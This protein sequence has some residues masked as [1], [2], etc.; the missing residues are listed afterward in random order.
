MS[1]QPKVHDTSDFPIVRFDGA[2]I[3]NG[4]SSAWCAEMDELVACGKPFVLIYVAGGPEET[5]D[6]RAQPRRL[7][8]DSQRRRLAAHCSRSSTS[9]RVRIMRA[10]L[11]T[12]LPKLVQAFGTPQSTRATTPMPRRWPGMSWRVVASKI[13][14]EQHRPVAVA[15]QGP[16]REDRLPRALRETTRVPI[17]GAGDRLL[18]GSGIASAGVALGSTRFLKCRNQRATTF[19]H[20]RRSCFSHPGAR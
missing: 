8:E 1:Q 19:T 7:A 13:R 15:H 4:Y 18:D 2:S 3:Y 14:Y 10:Q 16:I 6:D 17:N 11:E 9:N 12:M 5:L 20:S